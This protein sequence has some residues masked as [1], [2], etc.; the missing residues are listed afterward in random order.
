MS[1]GHVSPSQAALASWA[2]TS[3]VTPKVRSLQIS[4]DRAEVVLDL[5]QHFDDWVYCIERVDGWH[6]TVDGNGPCIG[7]DDPTFVQW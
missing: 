2:T 5:G 6:V 4:G 7:W 3:G 1:T